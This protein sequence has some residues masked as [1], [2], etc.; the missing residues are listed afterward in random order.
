M[1]EI[2]A[3]ELKE[4]MDKN[5]EINLVDVRDTF[6]ANISDFK[7]ETISIPLDDLSSR[8]SELDK[9][10]EYVV[11]CRSG[12]RSKNA[13]KILEENG[14]KKA[15]SLQGGINGWAQKYDPSLPQY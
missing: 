4:K 10:N 5:E 7:T 12:S 8:L 15:K 11:Y 14:F 2:T 1:V 3:E 9:G 13:V 6:E